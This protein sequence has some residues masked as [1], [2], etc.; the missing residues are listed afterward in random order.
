MAFAYPVQ[1][2]AQVKDLL[3]DL[4]KAHPKANHHCYAYRLGAAKLNTRAHD[5]GEP[6]GTAGKPIL[7]QIQSRDLTDVLVVVVRYF[8]GTLLGVS[9]LI[10]AYRS[11]AAEAL[12]QAPVIEKH[13]ECR[14]RATFR[15]EHTS[16]I[17]KILKQLDARIITQGYEDTSYLVFS[18][19]QNHVAAIEAQAGLHNSPFLSLVFEA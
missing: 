5:D 12:Q 10:Q 9:G 7:G 14:Y 2:D 4:R 13:V 11:A 6:S 3:A 15:F 8:G 16:E 1:T 19:R 17:M 18:I